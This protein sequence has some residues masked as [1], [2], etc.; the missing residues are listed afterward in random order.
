MTLNAIAKLC[1]CTMA[2]AATMPLAAAVETVNGIEWNYTV[3]NGKAMLGGGSS[4]S[5]A[6]STSTSGSITIPSTLGGCPVTSIG[7]YAFYDC[8]M[9]TSV[10]I[11]SSVTSIGGYAFNGCSGIRSVVVPQ[12]VC[13]M[14][15]S[16]VFPSAHMF[17]TNV[18]ISGDVTI[19]GAEAFP[20]AFSSDNIS[21]TFD[22]PVDGKARFTVTR[23][24]GGVA[25]YQTDN[26][27][28]MR[29]KV[30]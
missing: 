25:P 24:D 26:S 13:T 8:R 18:V 22:T 12:C 15:L 21:I 17:I 29:V 3:S 1:A 28:F 30:K 16:S 20:A 27:F 2:F 19:I 11:P 9:L 5:R 6:V 23:R 14:R 7:K 4:L 10:M